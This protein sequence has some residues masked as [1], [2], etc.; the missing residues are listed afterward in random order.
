LSRRYKTRNGSNKITKVH[1]ELSYPDV[2]EVTTR[3]GVF[4]ILF[5]FPPAVD[6]N[7]LLMTL[8]TLQRLRGGTGM[9]HE[10]LMGSL[11]SLLINFFPPKIAILYRIQTTTI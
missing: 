1:A 11:G 6:A 4:S 9:L 3:G 2:G 8:G 7:V 5:L 10:P